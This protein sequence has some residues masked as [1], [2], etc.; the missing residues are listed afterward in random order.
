MDNG[1]GL[2]QHQGMGLLGSRSPETRVSAAEREYL[3]G[4]LK[5][6]WAEDRLSLQT[7]AH[8]LDLLYAARTDRELRELVVDLPKPRPFERELA[9]IAEWAAECAAACTDAWGRACAPRLLLPAD[10]SVVLGRSHGC[11]CVIS[12]PEVSRRHAKLTHTETGWTLRDLSSTNG[13]Y[14]NGAR[15]TDTAC[16]QP[17][18][19]V[20]LGSTRFRLACAERPR[21]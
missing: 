12:D 3:V 13:T 7:F 4:R 21:R 20:W 17:G 18:D 6:A 9:R 11:G 16:V 19:Q 1:G 5:E 8:R 10:G 14:V 15:I 2:W